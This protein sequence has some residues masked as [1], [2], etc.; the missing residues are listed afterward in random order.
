MLPLVPISTARDLAHELFHADMPDAGRHASDSLVA[1]GVLQPDPVFHALRSLVE[2]GPIGAL[3]RWLDGQ[4]ESYENRSPITDVPLDFTRRSAPV[5][6]PHD[7][8]LAA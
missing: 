6:D 2:R 3:R 5:A 4:R 1:E 8:D 7:D